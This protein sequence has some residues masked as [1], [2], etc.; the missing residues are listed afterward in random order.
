MGSIPSY[1]LPFTEFG[2][3]TIYRVILAFGKFSFFKNHADFGNFSFGGNA[4]RQNLAAPAPR[5]QRVRSLSTW[6]VAQS[7]QGFDRTVLEI[8][9]ARA[10]V[11]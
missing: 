4:F 8:K 10:C 9:R 3:S 6:T 11:F 1:I 5:S 7:F 2:N